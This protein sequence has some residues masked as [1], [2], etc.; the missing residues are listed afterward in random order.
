MEGEQQGKVGRLGTVVVAVLLLTNAGCIG[1]AVGV[2]AAGGAAAGYAYLRGR[3]YRDYNADQPHGVA[4]VKASLA[5]LQFP[6]LGEETGEGKH[7][8]ES[9]TTDGTPIK[10][11]LETFPSRIPVEGSITRIAVRVGPFGDEV[12]SAR[13]LDQVNLHLAPPPQLPASGQAV[14]MPAPAAALAPPPIIVPA[15]ARPTETQPPPL[16]GLPVTPIPTT[17]PGTTLPK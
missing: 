16:A 5:E 17:A 14:P 12:V 2:A 4:A 13:I 11:Q 9:K 3:L 6:L 15:S 7:T 8:I 10:I 1:V